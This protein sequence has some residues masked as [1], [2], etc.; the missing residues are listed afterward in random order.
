MLLGNNYNDN[1]NEN[2]KV[3]GV[4]DGAPAYQTESLFYVVPDV[5]KEN[6]TGADGI[7]IIW[8]TGNKTIE[9][10]LA[11]PDERRVELIDGVFYDMAAPSYVHQIIALDAWKCLID[12]VEK[13]GGSCMPFAAPADVQLFCDSDKTMVQPDVFVVC[14]KERITM[15]RL[16]GA[17]DLVMEV[18]SPGS[19]R[20]DAD[21][22]LRKYRE[23]GVREYWII[24]PDDQQVWVYDLEAARTMQSEEP[25]PQVYTFADKV[26]VGIWEGKCEVDFA[27]IYERCQFLYGRE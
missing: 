15:N 24:F 26:P 10:Y 14:D 8:Q 11:L 13:N 4:M 17:P 25:V 1:G 16:L 22:K 3:H 27:E 2:N 9:D 21:L 12:F 18:A 23:S 20:R 5:E 19:R 7:Q 6:D